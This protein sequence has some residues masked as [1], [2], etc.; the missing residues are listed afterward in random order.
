[1]LQLKWG[2]YVWAAKA[3]LACLWDAHLNSSK[4][5]TGYNMDLGKTWASADFGQKCA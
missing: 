1:M 5:G 2:E 4:G 3:L